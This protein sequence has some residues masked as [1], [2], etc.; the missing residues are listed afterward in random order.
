M[1]LGF[2][3]VAGLSCLDAHAQSHGAFIGT[4]RIVNARM[5]H[6]ATLLNDGR[7][8]WSAQ[9]TYALHKYTT[10]GAVVTGQP[11]PHHYWPFADAI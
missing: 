10:G 3:A 2:L 6:T 9:G 8:L 1:L 11:E 5:E 4:G 7:G